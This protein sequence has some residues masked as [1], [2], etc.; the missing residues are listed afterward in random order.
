MR[1]RV[2]IIL[3]FIFV[4][5][6]VF[7]QPDILDKM[8]AKY[9]QINSF[10]AEFYQTLTNAATKEQEVRKGIIYYQKPG[11]ILW[12]V[13]SPDPEKL[14]VGEKFVW[15]Y[16]PEENTV[17]KYRR[18]QILTSKTML[19]FI[20]GKANVKEDFVPEFQGKQKDGLKF[21]L[22][23]KKPEPSLVL[24]Y[25]W[26]DKDSYLLN[27][28]MLIDFFGNGNELSIVNTKINQEFNPNLFRFKVKKDMEVID[29]TSNS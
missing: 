24:A 28:V 18:E 13:L 27:R 16:F 5:Q 22:V 4:S 25:V 10:Q 3:F 21:K 29:N 15:D 26:I 12:E 2:L 1:L 8:Q 11:L 14:V 20:S 19:K 6:G 23:P 7:A 17:Y 9:E